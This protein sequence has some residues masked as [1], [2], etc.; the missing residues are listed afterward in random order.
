MKLKYYLR[1]LGVGI[2]VTALLM[3]FA[4]QP[5]KSVREDTIEQNAV[6]TDVASVEESSEEAA[7][8]DEKPALEPEETE[9]SEAESSAEA[10]EEISVEESSEEASEEEPVEEPAEES[11]EEAE[12]ESVEES[13][14][15][16]H[17]PLTGT[18]TFSIV[19]G[20]S[21]DRVARKLYDLGL[22]KDAKAFDRYL[23]QNGY[24]KRISTGNYEV[25]LSASEEEIAKTI[26]GK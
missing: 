14:E 5:P 26:A 25:S 15:E 9:E 18:I 21:S 3:G 1:A 24:D 17:E 16:S 12:E 7:A 23:C 10:E 8:S 11:T 19:K 20:D 4:T 2:V 6:L 22:V 13:T